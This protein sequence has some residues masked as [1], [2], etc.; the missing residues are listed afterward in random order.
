MVW[1]DW[2]FCPHHQRNSGEYKVV[3]RYSGKWVA[4]YKTSKTKP[5]Q[6]QSW[7][8]RACLE[9]WHS[10]AEAWGPRVFANFS[11]IERP[12][13][14][15][16]DKNQI[17]FPTLNTAGDEVGET[18]LRLRPSTALPKDRSS[19]PSVHTRVLITT[20]KRPPQF[21][22]HPHP[23]ALVGTFTLVHI[24]TNQHAHIGKNR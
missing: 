7:W 19:G 13:L 9:S 15:T 1:S 10:G 6:S 24:P 21:S 22:G 16:Q 12:C 17:K 2:G 8:H 20:S 11:Y 5:N 4:F 14:K 18:A 23:L 3:L